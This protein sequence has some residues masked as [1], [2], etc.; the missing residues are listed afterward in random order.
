MLYTVHHIF[1]H[2]IFFFFFFFFKNKNQS[3]LTQGVGSVGESLK[4]LML[5]LRSLWFETHLVQIA[6]SGKPLGH[7]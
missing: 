5:A 1:F 3:P 4:L 6:S 2:G 7:V